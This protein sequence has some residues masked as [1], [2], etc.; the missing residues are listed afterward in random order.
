[1]ASSTR[2]APW[3]SGELDWSPAVHIQATGRVARDGQK[4]PVVSYYLIADTGS[5]PVVA[6]VLGVKREQLLGAID[7]DADTVENLEIDPD[8]VKLLAAHYLKSA[9]L[10]LPGPTLEA[11]EGASIGA[12][13]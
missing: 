7:P 2:A 9:G 12:A 3:C 13:P 5:D 8:R 10:T 6:D 1:M 4:E 11:A